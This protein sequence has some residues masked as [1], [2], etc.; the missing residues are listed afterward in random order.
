M[1]HGSMNQHR[2]FLKNIMYNKTI[3]IKSE[4]MQNMYIDYLHILYMYNLNRKYA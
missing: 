4:N 2:N 1:D 3:S